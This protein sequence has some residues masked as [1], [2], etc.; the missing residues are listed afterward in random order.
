MT[1]PITTTQTVGPFFHEAWR[2][3]SDATPAQ[4]HAADSITVSGIIRDGAGV[5]INDAVIE[6]WLPDVAA[7]EQEQLLPGF[8]RVPSNDDGVFQITLPRPAAAAAA[9]GT[10][11]LYV[12]VFARGLV[13]HQF[14]AVFL[15]DDAGLA[16]SP[17][18]NQVPA[19]RRATLVARRAGQDAYAWDIHMQGEHETV[20]FDYA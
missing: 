13:K 2:W 3:A 9:A 14:S 12:T 20:F 17:F 4:P 7:A 11:A 15:E 19:A 18:L 1:L 10:P 8:R 6:A 16:S 5:A